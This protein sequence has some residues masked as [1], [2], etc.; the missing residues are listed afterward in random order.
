MVEEILNDHS[1][2]KIAAT[3]FRYGQHQIFEFIGYFFLSI[4]IQFVG[5]MSFGINGIRIGCDFPMW[6]QYCL[7]IYMLSFIA[8]FG[9]FYAKMYMAKGKRATE[10]YMKH[11][12][13]SKS[14]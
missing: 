14:E 8:L 2:G 12:Q 4:Q 6:M 13:Q 3:P 1:I 5:A 11:I 9:N 10:N 7:V